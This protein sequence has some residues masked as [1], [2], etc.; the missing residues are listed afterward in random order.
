[1][2]QTTERTLVSFDWALKHILRDKANFDVLEGF[3]STLLN[4]EIR[5]LSLLESEA[6]QQHDLDKYNRVDLLAVDA[7]AQILIIELQYTWQPS[8]LKRLLYGTSKLVVENI[9]VGESFDHVRKV[10]SI[11]IL[12][13]PVSHEED[14][15]LYH[16]KTEF[17]G[18][19][20]NK[21]L[22]V[23]MAR[24]PK[25]DKSQ[26]GL[27]AEK[28]AASKA[29]NIFPEYYLIEVE[30][31]QNIIHQPIDEWVY[32]FKNSQVRDDFR[33]KNIQAAK[34]KLLLL[35]MNEAERKAYEQ[36]QISRANALDVLAGQYQEGIE[37]GIAIGK[38]TANRDNARKMRLAGLDLD[39][40]AK[41]S[42]LSESE[43]LSL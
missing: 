28:R 31:F 10:I 17:T 40:I 14:D 25:P 27:A 37:Q 11:S 3:L 33:S 19:H 15:Y 26:P 30:H 2:P 6:N 7:N 24:L 38:E 34:E 8:Y 43:I 36:F 22:W 41:I 18:L 13:F 12:Y 39:L 21:A 9:K 1:M 5:V 16:G 42:G 4:E 29:V 23:D 35:H 20:N 32:L